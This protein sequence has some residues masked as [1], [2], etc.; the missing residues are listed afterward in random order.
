MQKP[1]GQDSSSDLTLN[2]AADND[3]MADMI[4]LGMVGIQDPLR[5]GVN[6]AVIDCKHA[7]VVVRMGHW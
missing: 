1:V 5:P 3:N 7:G 2:H 4:F 6:E